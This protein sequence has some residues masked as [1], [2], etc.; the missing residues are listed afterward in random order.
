MFNAVSS[1][2][3]PC[4][5][6][7]ELRYKH[8]PKVQRAKPQ[9]VN[10]PIQKSDP[11]KFKE[12]LELFNRFH[13]KFTEGLWRADKVYFECKGDLSVTLRM[14]T[15]CRDLGKD[16]TKTDQ[17]YINTPEVARERTILCYACMHTMINE[18]LDKNKIADV[19]E[20]LNRLQKLQTNEI[21]IS[22]HGDHSH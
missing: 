11:T 5:S 13:C 8:S 12:S 18:F 2:T 3:K 16:N 6:L 15:K 17:Y 9:I 19:P 14:C 20:E 1:A 4:G 7:S 22:Y 10:T 21:S